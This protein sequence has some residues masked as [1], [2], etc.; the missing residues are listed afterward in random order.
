MCSGTFPWWIPLSRRTPPL[1][2]RATK[3]DGDQT[4][5]VHAIVQLFGAFWSFRE[6]NDDEFVLKGAMGAVRPSLELRKSDAKVG[7][8]L[9]RGMGHLTH[10]RLCAA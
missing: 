2:S 8:T 5:N 1:S 6:P 10:A 9:H 4:A 3:D 7:Q